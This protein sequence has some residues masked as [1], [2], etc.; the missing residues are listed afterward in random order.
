MVTKEALSADQKIYSITELKEIGYSQYK[1]SKLV[2]EGKLIKLNKSFYEN[3][4][5]QGEE[6]DFYYAAAYVPNGIIGFM[7]AAVYYGL[8]NYRPKEVDVIVK[9]NSYISP[10]P[11]WPPIKLHYM[12]EKYYNFAIIT[13]NENGNEFRIYEPEKIVADIVKYRERIGIEETKEVLTNY[14]KKTD[15]N[16]NK[17]IKYAKQMGCEKQIRTYMEVLI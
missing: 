12:E 7:S 10:F 15:R 13:I 2:E 8:S 16:L 6:S 9:A 11:D 14:L 5:Y 3:S 17:L 1:V 4:E